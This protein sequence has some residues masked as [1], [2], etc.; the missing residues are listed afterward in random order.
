MAVCEL[1]GS[2]S[3]GMK[4]IVEGVTLTVCEKCS[5]FGKVLQ[6]PQGVWS[7]GVKDSRSVRPA[8]A[9][10]EEFVVSSVGAIIR[11]FREKK[12]KTQKEFSSLLGVKESFLQHVES[13]SSLPDIGTARK[14]ERIVGSKLVVSVSGE[15]V[16]SKQERG[17]DGPM[18]LGDILK[19]V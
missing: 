4:A 17:K 11:S 6:S 16:S 14:W 1:C 18:T 13:G 19:K 8:V 2:S 15:D 7:G 3:A 5:K 10:P 12:G 9:V